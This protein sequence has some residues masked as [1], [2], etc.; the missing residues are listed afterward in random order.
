MN[1]QPCCLILHAKNKDSA[2]FIWKCVFYNNVK[3]F[4]ILYSL[5]LST[6]NIMSVSVDFL[7]HSRISLLNVKKNPYR[8]SFLGCYCPVLFRYLTAYFLFQWHVSSRILFHQF[9]LLSFAFY[10][11]LSSLTYTKFVRRL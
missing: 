7:S 4:I 5:D 9:I 10:S 2:L 11:L 8:Y 1:K 6:L 3:F